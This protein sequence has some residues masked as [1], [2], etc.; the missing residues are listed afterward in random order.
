MISNILKVLLLALIIQ[1]CNTGKP[2]TVVPA[3]KNMQWWK[4][5][6]NRVVAL[7]KSNFKVFFLGDS[8]TQGWMMAEYGHSIWLENFGEESALNLGFAGD[9]TQNL[10]WRIENGELD[11]ANPELVILMIGT[12]NAK[13]DSAEDIA[14]G[15]NA[16]LT[17]IQTKLPKTKIIVHRIFPRGIESEPLRLVT[18]QASEIFSKSSNEQSIHYLDINNHFQDESENVP[19]DIMYDGVHLTTKGYA[20]WVNA[21]AYLLPN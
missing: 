12:N 7:D 13:D 17:V 8:I 21:I 4:D 15:V 9:K 6:H 5:R 16:I 2:T 10:L 19:I 20:I 11:G 3:S 18:N 1:A 14:E